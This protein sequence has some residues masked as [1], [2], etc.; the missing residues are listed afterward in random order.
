MQTI[1]LLLQKY[2]NLRPRDSIVKEAFNKT[3]MDVFGED[4][5]IPLITISNGSIR[6]EASGPLKSEI[7]LRKEYFQ[8][9]FL[10]YLGEKIKIDRIN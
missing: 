2:A 7:L 9:T 1:T 3:F 8:E 6:I 4:I 10:N 5:S